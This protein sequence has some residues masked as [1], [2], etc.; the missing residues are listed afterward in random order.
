MDKLE[1]MMNHLRNESE[2]RV[3][4]LEQQMKAADTVN[5]SRNENE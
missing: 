1:R 3:R 4:Q 2:R 5:R